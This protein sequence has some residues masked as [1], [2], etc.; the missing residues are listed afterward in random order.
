MGPLVE[1]LA[2]IVPQHR[3]NLFDVLRHERDLNHRRAAATL[4]NWLGEDPDQ[5]LADTMPLLD[6]PD[7]GVRNNLSR[8]MTQFVGKVR[9]KRLRH[10]LIDSFLLQIQR[11]SHGDRNKGVYD[12]LF[13]AQASPADCKY[14]RRRGTEPIHY[15][16]DNSIVFNV[17]DPAQ[18]LLA[19]VEP[20]KP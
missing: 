1:R 20:K 3:A 11:P 13:M 14:I 7:G 2:Q 4:L 17:R 8:F 9:S 5:M 6:D 12:L 10:R 18:E 15:L 19:L 16:A